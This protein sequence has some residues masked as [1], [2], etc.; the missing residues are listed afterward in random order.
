LP[1]SMQAQMLSFSPQEAA[2]SNKEA[3]MIFFMALKIR[4]TSLKIRLICRDRPEQ[5]HWQINHWNGSA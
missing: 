1:D 3:K 5:I 4:F 2:T